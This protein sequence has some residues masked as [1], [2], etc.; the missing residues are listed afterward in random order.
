MNFHLYIILVKAQF[1]LTINP[2]GTDFVGDIMVSF[3]IRRLYMENDVTD[4]LLKIW[5]LKNKS[6]EKKKKII[7]TTNILD[8]KQKINSN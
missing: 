8:D 3:C 7:R 5:M 6:D 4:N 1:F 2:R